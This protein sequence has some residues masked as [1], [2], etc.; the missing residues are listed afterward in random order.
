MANI[1]ISYGV[2][3][4]SSTLFIPAC[5][6]VVGLRFYTRHVQKLPFGIDDWLMLPA[7]VR[8]Q[9]VS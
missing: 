1:P 3:L 8:Y 4:T 7:L 9:L 6:L 2:L 5:T